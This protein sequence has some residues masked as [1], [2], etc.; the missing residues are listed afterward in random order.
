MLFL[1]ENIGTGGQQTMNYFYVKNTNRDRNKIIIGH[2]ADGNLRDYFD[3]V[4]DE[5][6]EVGTTPENWEKATKNPLHVLK[7]AWA[8]RKILKSKKVD[9][10]FSNGSYTY[11]IAALACFLTSCKHGRF[12][13][14]EPSKERFLWKTF[15]LI[16]LHLFTDLYL[17]FSYGNK[18]LASRG[19]KEEKL[20]DL[21]N[22]V[23]SQLFKPIYSV[24]ERREYREKLGVEKDEIVIGW[25]G[26]LYEKINGRDGELVFSLKMA[27]AMKE[28]GFNQFK[29]LVVGDGYWKDG[30]KE[31][32]IEYNLEENM[33]YAGWQLP[34][35]VP[36]FINLMDI[37]PLLDYDPIGGS[38]VREA[39]SCGSVVLSV[40]GK[41][42]YQASWV[43]NNQNGILVADDN[44][45][46]RAA[47]VC[48]DLQKNPHKMK[49]LSRK[50]REYAVNHMD[51]SI[52]AKHLE[53]ACLKIIKT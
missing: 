19:V 23:D 22:A 18:E 37:V 30:L 1:L 29:F 40:N 5:I 20:I 15:H 14:K 35:K 28:K 16:P 41:S 8:F 48:I 12:L 11:I 38:I 39:M 51:F 17:G 33:I 43:K 34:E 50:G 2:Y 31:R 6:I 13:G 24:E 36:H 21:G 52:K 47:D 26:R 49:N 3:K 25:V 10:V 46:E 27:K 4:S 32:A 44:F 7:R 42:G 53:D 45:I 9:I